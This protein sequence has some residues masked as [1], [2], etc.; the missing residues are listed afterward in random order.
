[1]QVIPALGAALYAVALVTALALGIR[2]RA[3][4]RPGFR[5]ACL[6]L[7]LRIVW[8]AMWASPHR[9]NDAWRVSHR[10]FSGFCYATF[11]S[12]C[13]R[14]LADPYAVLISAPAALRRG[15]LPQGL[16]SVLMVRGYSGQR[17]YEQQQERTSDELVTDERWAEA[18]TEATRSARRLANVGS[19]LWSSF[20][21]IW[22]V[23]TALGKE[24]SS[25]TDAYDFEKMATSAMSMLL[26]T[27]LAALLVT[28][29]GRREW[30]WPLL[31]GALLLAMARTRPP[32]DPRQRAGLTRGVGAGDLPG[33]RRRAAHRD[34]LLHPLRSRADSKPQRPEP[35]GNAPRVQPPAC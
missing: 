32:P 33:A 17:E 3:A 29:W 24:R 28:A 9:D 1:M 5:L 21:L 34:W 8:E 13:L 16:Q 6:F 22:A 25:V 18:N 11:F 20:C 23:K 4:N 7:A 10:L 14:A 15:L 31:V 26:M 30:P 2:G 12:A 35:T 27:I 19:V